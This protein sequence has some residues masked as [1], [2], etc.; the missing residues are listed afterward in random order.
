MLSL[1]K[2]GYFLLFGV[3]LT[4]YEDAAMV[5]EMDLMEVIHVELPDEGWESIMSKV[6]GEDDFFEFLLVQNADALVF[7]VPVDDPRV[8]FGLHKVSDTR[9]M[10]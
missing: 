6:F 7:G 9:R 2:I 5:S 8:F 4:V 1:L 3:E 10:L